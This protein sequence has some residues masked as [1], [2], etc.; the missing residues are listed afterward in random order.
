MRA[1]ILKLIILNILVL[2]SEAEPITTLVEFF[3]FKCRHCFE[4]N[5]KLENFV[6]KN[7]IKYLDIN[8][9]NDD[10]AIPTNILYYIA[11]DA[12]IGSE[13]KR[14]YFE[15][16][17]NGMKDYSSTTLNYVF[18]QVKTPKMLQL[19]KSKLEQEHVK[20]KLIYANNLLS[21]YRIQ[22]TPTFLVNQTVLLEGADVID[23]L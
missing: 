15:A 14:Q 22:V 10:R 7:N 12:G 4:I 1:K 5:T 3:S 11:I 19:L 8:V 6:A 13:F 21:T 18:N 2:Y 23:S 9:D 20:Q 16:L 17:N